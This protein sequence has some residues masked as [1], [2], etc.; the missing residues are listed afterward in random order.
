LE[1]Y[2]SKRRKWLSLDAT[3]DSRLKPFFKISSWNGKN[4]TPLA[5]KSIKRLSLEE[6]IILAKETSKKDFIGDIKTN[7]KFYQAF[8]SWLK[9]VRNK[10]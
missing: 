10:S 3:W 6:G 5:V 4:A 9:E 2:N 7:G 8:N 1:F